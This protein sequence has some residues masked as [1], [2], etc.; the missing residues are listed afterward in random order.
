MAAAMTKVHRLKDFD[1]SNYARV[2]TACGIVAYIDG[3]GRG[4][5][6]TAQGYRY[7]YATDGDAVTCQRCLRAQPDQQS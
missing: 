7:Q 1:R 5:M 6:S 3:H 4:E 2:T